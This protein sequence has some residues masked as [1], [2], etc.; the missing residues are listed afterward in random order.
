MEA[1]QNEIEGD[2]ANP[3]ERSK[4]RLWAWLS[5]LDADSEDDAGSKAAVLGE[6]RN[7]MG[8]PVPDGF[9]LTT[10]AYRQYCGIPLWEK[11][12][13]AT[14]D[15]N[16][17]DAEVIQRVSAR[18]TESVMESALPHSIETAIA[19][20]AAGLFAQGGSLAVRSSARGEGNARSYAG[21]FLSLLNVPSD[22]AVEAYR[23]VIASRFSERALFYRLSTG[24]PEVDTPMAALFVKMIPARAAGIMYTRDPGD[25]KVRRSGS[26]RHEVW[27]SE[28]P[29]AATRPT[30]FSWPAPH[31]MPWSNAA[32]SGK[33]KKLYCKTEEGSPRFP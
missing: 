15:L 32:W 18:L 9:V 7:R 33:K 30:S 29:A 31:H 19:G 25:P 4:A 17:N 6:I 3:E 21:Q 11:I 27:G 23:R 1:Q 14:R 22:R 28:S 5:E 12:R 13:D 24:L 20:G 16:L 2:A 10:D 8:L 26:P